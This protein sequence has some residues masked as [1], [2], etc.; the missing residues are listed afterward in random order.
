MEDRSGGTEI[1]L[2]EGDGATRQ[3]IFGKVGDNCGGALL[4]CQKNA[5]AGGWPWPH[6]RQGQQGP[7]RGEG[8]S[9]SMR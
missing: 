2:G 8:R 4:F 1:L 3:G 7:V 5:E 6:Q 9:A